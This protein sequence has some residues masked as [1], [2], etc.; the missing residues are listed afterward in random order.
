MI[1]RRL[2][3]PGLILVVLLAAF[4]YTAPPVYV[5]SFMTVIFMY[6]ALSESWTILG[7]Y[8]GYVS[9]GHVAFF[10]IGAY[11]TALLLLHVGVNPLFSFPLG[12]VAAALFAA[13]VGYPIV[14]L[15]GPY[16]SIVTLLVALLTSL[17]VKNTP[18]LGGTT[19]LWLP[20]PD[21]PIELNRTT[22]YWFMLFMALVATGVTAWV[23]NSKLGLGLMAIRQNEAVAEAAGANTTYIKLAALVLSAGLTGMV[24]GIYGYL[25]SYVTPEIVF[26]LNIGVTLFLMALFG[27]CRRWQGPVLGAVIL[28]VLG[29]FLTLNIGEE[30]ARI[31]YG[32][33]LV[34]VVFFPD[35]L[36]G[37]IDKITVNR[38]VAFGG[39]H[40][41]ER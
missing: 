36:V 38:K 32:L 40:A 16:F 12:G 19:G 34:L 15:Q 7:G 17:V 21:M 26:D 28:S 30:I 4:P 23:E 33:C 25:R 27:G 31:A 35:G 39:K 1:G 14:R 11:T 24:G 3:L 13:V 8:A 20:L 18:A 29:E 10:G 6:I 5:L 37:I 2:I 22:F 9:F 41:V